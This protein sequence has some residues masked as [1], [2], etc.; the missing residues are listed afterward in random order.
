MAADLCGHRRFHRCRNRAILGQED[1]IALLAL[2]DISPLHAFHAERGIGLEPGLD[3]IDIAIGYCQML[4]DRPMNERAPPPAGQGSPGQAA[5]QRR[6]HLPC[7]SRR[8]YPV[9]PARRSRSPQQTH[10]FYPLNSGT[11]GESET[12]H[13]R[14]NAAENHNAE[15]REIASLR[16]QQERPSSRCWT[17]QRMGSASALANWGFLNFDDG[18]VVTYRTHAQPGEAPAAPAA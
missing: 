16:W 15:Q 18:G 14:R 4:R 9:R 5:V 1:L 2:S 12:W 8:T 13:G 6:P 17:G 11:T 7:R 10:R 3:R